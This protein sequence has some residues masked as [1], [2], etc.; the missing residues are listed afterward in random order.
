M[1]VT[2]LITDEVVLFSKNSRSQRISNV[3]TTGVKHTSRRPKP[4]R[5]EVESGPR[6][7]FVK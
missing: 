4:A 6:D 5:C 2:H 7:D 1:N 3:Y